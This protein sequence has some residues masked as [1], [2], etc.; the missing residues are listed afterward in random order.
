[1]QDND[2]MKDVE[3]SPS[4]EGEDS[5]VVCF[6]ISVRE[7][8]LAIQR[9][10][11]KMENIRRKTMKDTNEMNDEMLDM[12]TKLAEAEDRLLELPEEEYTA[13]ITE[14]TITDEQLNALM[15][16]VTE[17]SKSGKDRVVRKME[18]INTDGGGA[19]ILTPDELVLIVHKC[20]AILRCG[21]HLNEG[22]EALTYALG[23]MCKFVTLEEREALAIIL[24]TMT[25]TLWEFI[26][27]CYAV[28][29]V[30]VER[31][32]KRV[33][34]EEGGQGDTNE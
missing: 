1:M 28:T 6:R 19:D 7:L 14:L 29:L 11:D 24:K 12:D 21:M 10:L 16:I 31:E 22:L 30:S 5:R 9:E 26:G 17:A 2:E 13:K 8:E 15:A 32:R 18:S 3:D 33:M 27:L 20:K 23:A 4:T 34:S 25:E